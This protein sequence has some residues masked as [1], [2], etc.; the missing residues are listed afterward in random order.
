PARLCA[1]AFMTGLGWSAGRRAAAGPPVTGGG[2]PALPQPGGIVIGSQ[3][4]RNAARAMRNLRRRAA[5]TPAWGAR[6]RG[7]RHRASRHAACRPM[8]TVPRTIVLV[9]L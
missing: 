4:V 8:L 6:G 3:Y 7:A 9:G 5:R 2:T 1:S